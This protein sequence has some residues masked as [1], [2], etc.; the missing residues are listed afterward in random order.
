MNEID[1]SYEQAIVRDVESIQARIELNER[2]RLSVRNDAE[3]A[4]M[5]ELSEDAASASSDT[6]SD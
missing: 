4:A 2:P 5:D 3:V 6:D 1:V